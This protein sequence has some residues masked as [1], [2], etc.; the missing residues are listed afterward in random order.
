MSA[1]KKRDPIEYLLNAMERAAQSENPAKAG[2]AAK[3]KAVLDA[4]AELRADQ[5]VVMHE[6]FMTGRIYR[7]MG[8]KEMPMEIHAKLQENCDRAVRLS[9]AERAKVSDD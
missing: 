8:E 9:R 1:D 6:A 3:R 5:E 7:A 4:I 2:S